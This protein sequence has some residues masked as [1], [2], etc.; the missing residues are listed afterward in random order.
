MRRVW[1]E[2]RLIDGPLPIEASDRGLT[3]GDGLFETMLVVNKRPLW[4]HMHLARL[5]GSAKELGIGFDG[6][7]VDAAI[8]G[9]HD[10]CGVG[11]HS[12]RV[13]LTRG[14]V[15]RGLGGNGA[16]PT[17]FAT[18]E[19][20]DGALLFKPVTLLTA[21][22]RR[23]Q[24]SV[25]SRMKT[26]SYI[27]NIAAAREA[28]A[29]GADDA[30]MLNSAGKVACATIA[31]L[32]LFKKNRLITP[33]RDQGILTGVTRQALIAAAQHIGIFTEERAVTVVDLFRAD[34]AFLTN[35]LRLI[36]P[37][38]AIDRQP[39][40][41]PDLSALTNALCEAARL[42]CGADPRLI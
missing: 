9:L 29:H 22:I 4:R 13:T 38:T 1:F 37:I 21:S 3:L 26:L 23:S 41:Q 28:A 17:L 25:A 20:F 34:G 27:D 6:E 5:E 2:G 10:D 15:A 18:V 33:S 12:L 16:S 35:S 19:P 36:R 8:E 40:P 14:P 32:F 30:L 11:H 24:D 42:Q 7:A 39:M 31:N